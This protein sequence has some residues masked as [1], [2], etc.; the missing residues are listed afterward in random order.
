MSKWRTYELLV[1]NYYCAYCEPSNHDW[2]VSYDVKRNGQSGTERQIDVLLE[3][4]SQGI[5][6]IIDCKCYKTRI[7]IKHVETII[8][9]LDDLRAN[10]GV[11]VSP[12]GFSA[13]AYK[14]AADYGRLQ[15]KIIDLKDLFPHR[16]QNNNSIIH[17]CPGC[18]A[19]F[20]QQT[21]SNPVNLTG[22]DIVYWE[23][24]IRKIHVGFC[25][26]CL[27]QIFYCTECQSYICL[28]IHDI[29]K[30]IMKTC[31]CGIKYALF[32]YIDLYGNGQTIYRYFDKND[33]EL[34]T[35]NNIYYIYQ[36][37]GILLDHS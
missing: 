26:E 16:F 36:K 8:G 31:K 11:I 37:Y 29:Y 7:D 6:K 27:N 33:E 9:M 17:N 23:D 25:S 5:N 30:N 24:N 32:S 28:S 12:K 14:R 22:Y 18:R 20:F 15:L 1:Y 35:E 21:I 4:Q 2:K 3:S 34:I 10:A 13:A 19:S